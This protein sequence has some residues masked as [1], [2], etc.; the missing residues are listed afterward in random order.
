VKLIKKLAPLAVAASILVS[1][2]TAFAATQADVVKAL[3]DAKV[4][5]VYIIKAENYL[6]TNTLTDAQSSAVIAQI[7]EVDKIMDN[8]K[9]YDFTKL[10]QTDKD[11]V[12]AAVKSAATSAN[13]N[14]SFTKNAA[15]QTVVTLVDSNGQTVLAASTNEVDMKKTGNN[16]TV[17]ILGSFMVI[18]A[19]GSL[20]VVKKVTA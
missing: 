8:A 4:P 3:K 13:L 6:K 16:S 2:T 20:L 1:S 18:A 19:A 17:L 15:G 9:V 12:I 14:V 5:E 11:K 7:N 10:T